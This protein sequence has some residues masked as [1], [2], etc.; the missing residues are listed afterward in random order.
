MLLFFEFQ[1]MS[2]RER[3]RHM[4]IIL[5]ILLAQQR[6][7]GCSLVCARVASSR[8]RL[9]CELNYHNPVIARTQDGNLYLAVK[10]ALRSAS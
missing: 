4:P 8:M 6:A 3:M 10:P 1:Q 9:V 7:C 5:G 2:Y